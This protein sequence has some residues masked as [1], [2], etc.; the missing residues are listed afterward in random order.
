MIM[1]IGKH[2]YEGYVLDFLDGQ[3]SG[4]LRQSFERFLDE[5]PEIKEE[6]MNLDRSPIAVEDLGPTPPFG[7]KEEL[8]KDRS[9]VALLKKPVQLKLWQIAASMVLL[10]SA[11]WIINDHFIGSDDSAV[12]AVSVEPDQSDVD[13]IALL[14][15][16][17]DPNGSKSDTKHPDEEEMAFR[18]PINK[19]VSRDDAE[20]SGQS[21]SVQAERPVNREMEER[22]DV[23]S[24]EKAVLAVGEEPAIEKIPEFVSTDFGSEDWEKQTVDRSADPVAQ[25]AL[26]PARKLTP[27]LHPG[28]R[29]SDLIPN[30]SSEKLGEIAG[31]HS[32]DQGRL[33]RVI[34]RFLPSVY[35][36]KSID[37]DRDFSRDQIPV[38]LIPQILQQ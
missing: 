28:M 3:L 26:L 33:A 32:E 21:T 20:R 12:I 13:K 35:S 23:E 1:D 25:L 36:V 7:R 38:A 10:L 34:D 5:H 9:V 4:D 17:A 30:F 16:K 29:S 24:F 14:D 18:K 8:Y 19:G 2:N 15:F 31:G 22:M 27:D 37:F 11:V 6:V